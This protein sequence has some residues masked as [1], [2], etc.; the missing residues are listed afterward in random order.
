VNDLD[1]HSE[2]D[3]DEPKRI[4]GASS[5]SDWYEG[6]E[7]ESG[8]CQTVDDR[9]I[10]DADR[11]YS[12]YPDSCSAVAIGDHIEQARRAELRIAEITGDIAPDLR[13]EA[14]F[15]TGD[16][17]A[18]RF[19]G[20]WGEDLRLLG[21]VVPAD[22]RLVVRD[23]MMTAQDGT[24]VHEGLH[25]WQIDAAGEALLPSA[26]NEAIIEHLTRE[27]DPTP[28]ALY[29]LA[30]DGRAKVFVPDLAPG[31][32]FSDDAVQIIELPGVYEEARAFARELEEIV[33][34]E[35]VLNLCRTIDHAAF[36]RIVDSATAPGTWG[37][38]LESLQGSPDDVDWPSVRR[39][40]RVPIEARGD[41]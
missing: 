21:F 4:E 15:L 2:F 22:G 23:S 30:T 32:E 8:I 16:R 17:F 35:S 20:D 33:G 27:A 39:I 38:T 11:L 3:E 25:R 36:G 1:T 29:D 5:R 6:W 12:E 34:R 41:S 7:T 40:L 31:E 19:P 37:R 26:L 14:E 9:C 13:R 18:D 10:L 24:L 28:E